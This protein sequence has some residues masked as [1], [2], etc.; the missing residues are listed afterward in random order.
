MTGEQ[1]STLGGVVLR[2]VPFPEVWHILLWPERS[3][4]EFL[5]FDKKWL[6]A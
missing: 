6:S 2:C 1:T 4:N 5:S 3:R